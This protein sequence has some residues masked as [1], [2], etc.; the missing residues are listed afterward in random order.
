MPANDSAD[1]QC[2]EDAEVVPTPPTVYDN[3]GDEITPT[4]PVVVSTPDPI[5]CAGTVTY[6][7]NYADCEG[8]NHDWTFTYNVEDTID[9]EFTDVPADDDLGCFPEGTDPG[10]T[11]PTVLYAEWEDNCA[12][13]G[14]VPS[15][16]PVITMI[17][18]CSYQAVYT[19]NIEDN[20]GN[21]A[22]ESTTLTMSVEDYGKC[23]TAFAGPDDEDVYERCFLEDGFN[24]WGWTNNI[25]E[26][27]EDPYVLPLWAGAAQCD[28]EK[29]N[30]AGEVRITYFNDQVSVVYELFAN[31]A[32]SEAHVY[33]GCE[34]YPYGPS[35][36]PTV[37]PGQYNFNAGALDH[38]GGYS[39]LNVPV[40]NVDPEDG[41]WVIAHARVCTI[42]CPQCYDRPDVEQD[43]SGTVVDCGNSIA[44]PNIAADV[45]EVPQWDLNF[46]AYPV[47]FNDYLNVSYDWDYDTPVLIQVFD[48][49]G[50]LVQEVSTYY[51]K[52]SEGVTRL[53]LSA[54]ENQMLFVKVTNDRG[55][56]ME[57]VVA[58]NYRSRQ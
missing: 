51:T 6:T 9:P 16:A 15:G 25:T 45:I 18:E 52:D 7:W 33:I 5:V 56:G 8:N 1:V 14:T 32:M 36:S 31:Y 49:K 13:G 43:G 2:P 22:T 39:L 50:M 42:E 11:F 47:P 37:A 58:N 24:R 3:C 28:T 48:I 41:I 40:V 4:G 26:Q 53:D 27:R 29:G 44:D 12:E 17:D 21:T 54:V 57:K 23:D 30:L 46:T 55:V 35:G 20:C 19:F 10:E 34:K 38:V